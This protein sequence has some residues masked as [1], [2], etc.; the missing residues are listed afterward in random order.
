M[1][2]GGVGEQD[3]VIDG[4]NFQGPFL[5]S[6]VT[7]VV[8]GV[9]AGNLGPREPG[10]RSA[11]RQDARESGSVPQVGMPANGGSAGLD[12]DA[13]ADVGEGRRDGGEVELLGLVLGERE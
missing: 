4:D 9:G 3:P 7:A 6:P 1:I 8:L 10:E 13:L 5:D 12:P 11:S 2:L